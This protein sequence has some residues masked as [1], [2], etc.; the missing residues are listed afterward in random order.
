MLSPKCGMLITFSRFNEAY[1]CSM[2]YEES[3]AS[4]SEDEQ[5]NIMVL[6]DENQSL[7]N[8]AVSGNDSR[9]CSTFKE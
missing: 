4:K 7:C 9:H 8:K 6:F 5:S 1:D 3:V 2:Q